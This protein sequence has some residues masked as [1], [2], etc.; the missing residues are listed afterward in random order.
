[1]GIGRRAGDDRDDRGE[2]VAGRGRFLVGS[3]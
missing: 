3:G 2:Q 1:M